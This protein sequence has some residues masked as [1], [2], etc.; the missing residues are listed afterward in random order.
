MGDEHGVQSYGLI[1]A[2][3]LVRTIIVLASWFWLIN[4]VCDLS[5]S[6]QANKNKPQASVRRARPDSRVIKSI[7]ADCLLSHTFEGKLR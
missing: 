6:N 5:A 7:A 3:D 1:Q 2:C 4:I